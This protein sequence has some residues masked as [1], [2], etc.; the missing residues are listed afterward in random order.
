V[1]DNGICRLGVFYDGTFFAR[2]QNYFYHD[3]QLGWLDFKELHRLLQ[4]YVR[5]KEPGFFAYKVVY[6]AWFQGLFTSS[7]AEERQLRRDR[8][9]HHDLMHAGIEAK[10]LPMSASEQEKG[11][12]VA[13]AVD[14]L[15]VG[16]KNQIDIA[17]LVTGDGDF[18]PLVRALNKNGIRVLVAYFTYEGKT[19]GKG[20]ANDRLL[21]A[22]N[23][24]LD[25][26]S[27]EGDKEFRTLFKALFRKP[28]KPA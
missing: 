11:V 24:E 8:N 28:E 18:V 19:S 4:E 1:L 26:C 15:Q 7:H 21:A 12:D 27:L 2:S 16:V 10:H 6:A 20:F 22:A 25:I 9:L 3:R 17:V 14:A 13:L 23:Y 5:T